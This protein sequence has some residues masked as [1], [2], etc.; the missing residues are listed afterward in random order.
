MVLLCR[1]RDSRSEVAAVSSLS[2][3]FVVI[4]K[5]GIFI[6]LAKQMQC[7]INSSLLFIVVLGWRHSYLGNGANLFLL[8]VILL[9]MA[10]ASGTTFLKSF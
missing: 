9:N 2:V 6:K 4:V 10:K 3:D 5:L 8:L 1:N 7:V